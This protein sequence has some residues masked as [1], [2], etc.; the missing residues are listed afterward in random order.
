MFRANVIGWIGRVLTKHAELED[1][2]DSSTSDSDD[3]VPVTIDFLV[4]VPSIYV[5]LPP[6]KS[7]ET[8]RRSVALISH[9][10][11]RG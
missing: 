11:G 7:H 4:G 1:G 9:I 2:E 8:P 10:R 3:N 5:T 6:G